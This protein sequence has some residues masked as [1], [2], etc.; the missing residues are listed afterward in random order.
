MVIPRRFIL[1]VLQ[2]TFFADHYRRRRKRSSYLTST[3]NLAV[4]YSEVERN[5][6]A[7]I[8]ARSHGQQSAT[9]CGVMSAIDEAAAA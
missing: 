1:E 8:P 9:E 6:D 4:F 3:N 7:S 2:R 5:R